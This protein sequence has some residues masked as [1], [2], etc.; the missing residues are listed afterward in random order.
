MHAQRCPVAKLLAASQTNKSLTGPTPP[1]TNPPACFH[2]PQSRSPGI[3]GLLPKKVN[4]R[5]SHH[6]SHQP[7]RN[8]EKRSF[9]QNL[10]GDAA[11][12]LT[13]CPQMYSD[14]TWIPPPF[15][16]EPKPF[17][18]DDD[19][20]PL[21]RYPD[22]PKVINENCSIHGIHARRGSRGAVFPKS[23]SCPVAPRIESR[24]TAN[25]ERL[26]NWRRSS[27]TIA[28]NRSQ[29]LGIVSREQHREVPPRTLSLHQP[30][31]G[32]RSCPSPLSSFSSPSTPSP[33]PMALS[34]K[35]IT[36]D[37]QSRRSQ[38]RKAWSF[39]SI[40]CDDIPKEKPPPKR[41]LRQPTRHVY[42]RGIS[43]LPIECTNRV[44]GL[45]F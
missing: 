34:K 39:F 22:L 11:P 32:R 20:P 35:R 21:E 3:K 29:S 41:I 31:E 45:A 26:K 12:L 40:G 24:Q 13:P 2:P 38:F 16:V 1:F 15:P 23:V 43:G 7:P 36:D 42:R 37:L 17:Y 9:F 19:E 10:H 44:M 8:L 33:P 30:I 14:D 18:P 5:V 27:L 4:S 28:S 6:R 25:A